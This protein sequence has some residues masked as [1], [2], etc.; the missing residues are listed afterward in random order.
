[1]I[2]APVVGEHDVG[3]LEVSVQ[4]ALLVRA[5]QAL[6]DF[7]REPSDRDVPSEPPGDRLLSGSPRTSSIAMK[8]TPSLRRLHE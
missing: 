1:M 6:G 8:L 5:R 2:F 7:C 4:N 3:G